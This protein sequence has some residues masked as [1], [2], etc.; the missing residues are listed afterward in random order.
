VVA[1]VSL[2]SS[3]AATASHSALL[4]GVCPL[5]QLPEVCSAGAFQPYC[6]AGHET[7]Q[8][9]APASLPRLAGHVEQPVPLA[10][11]PGAQAVQVAAGALVLPAGPTV[12]AA[13]GVPVHAE[14]EPAAA[15]CVPAGHTAQ[16]PLQ[17]HFCE[18]LH[19]LLLL[20]LLLKV[21][22][23]RSEVVVQQPGG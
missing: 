19:V 9:G 7:L 14:R 17:R 8:R 12:P 11:V 16:V 10:N 21:L 3:V 6:P 13:Q 1:V 2:T 5:P 22:K 18:V 15:A 23:K 4:S 20:L